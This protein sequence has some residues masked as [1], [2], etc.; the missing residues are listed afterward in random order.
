MHKIGTQCKVKKQKSYDAQRNTVPGR[1]MVINALILFGIAF[2][3]VFALGFQSRCVNHGNHKMAFIN[4][5]VI[6]TCNLG[7]LKMVPS[8]DSPVELAAFLLGGPFGIVASMWA[9]KKTLGRDK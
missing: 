9:H 6:G 1:L 5:L 2:I 7:I 3:T 4:S 8:T